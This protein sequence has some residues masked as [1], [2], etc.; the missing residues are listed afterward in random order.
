MRASIN[1]LGP[2]VCGWQDRDRLPGGDDFG[3]RPIDMHIAGLEAMGRPAHSQ[4][5]CS[6]CAPRLVGADI[7]F[8][9]PSVGATE[10]LVTAAVCA[11][12]VTTIDGALAG[13]S[14]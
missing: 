3:L 5:V 6:R 2:L 11:D 4:M 1:L 9:F 14:C 8:S 10:N 13:R 7:R 12:G